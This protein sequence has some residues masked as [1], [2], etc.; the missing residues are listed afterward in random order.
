MAGN[1]SN[2]FNQLQSSVAEFFM[3]ASNI[4]F[5]TCYL[6]VNVAI[7]FYISWVLGIAVI[8]WAFL[9]IYCGKYFGLKRAEL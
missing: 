2:K 9:M 1:I 6:L 8:F 4:V 5:D 7:L 3:N